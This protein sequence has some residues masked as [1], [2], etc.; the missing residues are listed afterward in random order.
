MKYKKLFPVFVACCL[1]TLAS[2]QF[3]SYRMIQLSR[4]DND[5]LNHL[6]T[7][8]FSN[9][10]GWYD[11]VKNREY[12][13][14]GSTDSTYFLDVTDPFKT[15]VVCDVK[16]GRSPFS[17][18]REYKT[19]EHYCYAVQ[20]AGLAA[21]QIF[22]LQYLPDSVHT[23]YDSDSL[24]ARTHTVWVEGDKL[25]CN[26]A[27]MRSSPPEAVRI[28]SLADPEN[29]A[30]IGTVV[31]P[32]F[33]GSPAFNNC[34]DAYVRNDTLF[35]SGE[36]S[37]MFI[38]DVS[39]PSNPKIMATISDYP[40]KGYNHSSYLTGDGKYL[41]FTDEN[42]GLGIKIYDISNLANITLKSVF[43]S[44]PGATAHNPYIIGDKLY[45]SYYHD[46]VYVFDIADPADPKV[47]AFYD[48][49]PQNGN[50]YGGFEGCWGIYPF[51]PSGNILAIDM[52]NGLFVLRMDKTAGMEKDA[53]GDFS[54]YP[55]PLA[56][57]VEISFENS[58]EQKLEV[59]L[60][61]QAGRL[62]MVKMLAVT[63]GANKVVLDMPANLATGMY[64]MNLTGSKTHICKKVVKL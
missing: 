40:E 61:D 26:S 34:H 64:F 60:V 54:V 13:I 35:C 12:A 1:S 6:G 4:W 58:G 19:Y 24:I 9:C 7:Q 5:S 3:N 11:P 2:A 63:P 43:R 8:T 62:L 33:D 46:G 57:R 27:K 44:N 23:V 53:I 31:P 47:I 49:Y 51:L 55:N 30:Y 29:P 45:V 37:G 20:D 10:W 52:T 50:N 14:V 21:L 15:P 42:A 25:Y 41:V 17:V 16:A 22:D 38:F 59:Q 32:I 39:T 28:L 48:T 56:D 36:N 18:W